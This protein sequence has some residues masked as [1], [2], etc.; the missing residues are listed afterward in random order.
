MKD[1]LPEVWGG[2][3][4]NLESVSRCYQTCDKALSKL[5]L[6][7]LEAS[8]FSSGCTCLDIVTGSC[9]RQAF[10]PSGTCNLI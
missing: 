3:G 8:T 7:P 5:E 4:C 10:C 1:H 9:D 6:G 2:D